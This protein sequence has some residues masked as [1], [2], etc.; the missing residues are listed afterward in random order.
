MFWI[1]LLKKKWKSGEDSEFTGYGLA[2]DA[3][4]ECMTDEQMEDIIQKYLS[5]LKKKMMSLDIRTKRKK[6]L[7]FLRKRR[8]S[9][10]PG[11]Y[12]STGSATDTGICGT[13]LRKIVSK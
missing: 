8:S 11:E 12:K 5:N 4:Q 1:P 3:W 13:E 2:N 9:G 7:I 10:K 6:D